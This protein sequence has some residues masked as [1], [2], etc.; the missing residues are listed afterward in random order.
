M[1]YEDIK[2]KQSACAIISFND[3]GRLGCVEL[4]VWYPGGLRLKGLAATSLD[5]RLPRS[6][7]STGSC[8]THISSKESISQMCTIVCHN[9]IKAWWRL[10]MTW[11]WKRDVGEMLCWCMS[12]QIYVCLV[13]NMNFRTNNICFWINFYLK[14][15]CLCEFC[16]SMCFSIVQDVTDV[17]N[18]WMRLVE[19]EDEW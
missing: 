3:R 4:A 11:G 15:K 10:A 7:S 6:L 18:R 12:T 19:Q 9:Y 8:L 16:D 17:T 5:I 14:Q 1:H 2:L 13:G